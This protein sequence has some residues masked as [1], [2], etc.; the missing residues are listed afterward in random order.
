[1]FRFILNSHTLLRDTDTSG[2]ASEKFYLISHCFDF[3]LNNLECVKYKI[4]N[5]SEATSI[6]KEYTSDEQLGSIMPNH[7]LITDKSIENPNVN[8]IREYINEIRKIQSV[9]SNDEVAAEIYPD[10]I[11]FKFED[12]YVTFKYSGSSI[13]LS[14]G[15]IKYKNK[16]YYALLHEKSAVIKQWGNLKRILQGLDTTYIK[17]IVGSPLT[18][19]VYGYSYDGRQFHRY[20]LHKRLN[21]I[22]IKDGYKMELC[23]HKGDNAVEK[24]IGSGILFFDVEKKNF[25]NA[26]S[27]AEIEKMVRTNSVLFGGPIVYK[28]LR[29]YYMD[30]L[31][32]NLD[33]IRP[34]D[35][36]PNGMRKD[37]F[38]GLDCDQISKFPEWTRSRQDE[39]YLSEMKNGG[40]TGVCA[41][42]K[43]SQPQRFQK[44]LDRYNGQ[45]SAIDNSLYTEGE[46]EI[47]EL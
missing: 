25:G 39:Y 2:W 36:Y 31:N 44:L 42:I 45:Q 17:N 20:N 26:V 41:Y 11:N 4:S 40:K 37:L 28:V 46:D 3:Y 32:D 47:D 12:K 38:K 27:D 9:L 13:S 14:G 16:V 43:Q 33:N 21:I 1:M 8:I 10:Y 18:E 29:D 35:R 19:K 24:I 6:E 15:D 7:T 22:T 23:N 5:V 34:Y 30:K